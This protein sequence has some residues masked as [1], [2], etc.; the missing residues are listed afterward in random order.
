MKVWRLEPDLSEVYK[1]YQ[2]VNREKPF[3]RIFCEKSDDGIR[4]NGEY[5]NV[6]I[7]PVEGM[8]DM[9]LAKFW[10]GEEPILTNDRA[11]ECLE[12]LLNDFVE[13]VPLKCDD[14]TLYMLHVVTVIEALDN[15]N[16]RYGKSADGRDVVRYDFIPERVEGI[17]IF[18]TKLENHV[19]STDIFVS[20][21]LKAIVEQNHLTG[22]KF[23]QESE[24]EAV[25]Y[26]K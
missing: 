9:D 2:L 20:P 3:F 6:E 26:K 10:T 8:K 13:F 15:E 23:I 17:P 12:D 4:F 19:H 14:R 18:K 5:D 24:V 1:S 25:C 11:K 7:Y 16:K 22:V 21:E